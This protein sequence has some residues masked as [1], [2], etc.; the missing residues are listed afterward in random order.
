MNNVKEKAP[1]TAATV[2]SASNNI[3][4]QNSTKQQDCKPFSDIDDPA[5]RVLAKII[6]LED[7]HYQDGFEGKPYCN[8]FTFVGFISMHG[9]P[10]DSDKDT[11]ILQ[12][13]YHLCDKMFRE[14][15]ERGRADATDI[16]V[17]A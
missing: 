12:S 4:D 13:L 16:A 6:H 11:P 5:L 10:A 9:E 14:S 17:G 3:Q 15:W 7:S 8:E 2:Q 1:S